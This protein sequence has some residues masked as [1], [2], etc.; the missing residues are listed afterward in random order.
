MAYDQATHETVLFGGFGNPEYYVDTWACRNGWT[1]LAPA[2]SPSARSGP[3]MVWDGA[4]E[5]IVLFGGLSSDGTSLNDTWTWDGSTWTQQFPAASP[6]PRRTTIA[7][8]DPTRTVVLFGGDSTNNAAYNDTWT[9]NGATWTRQSP[10]SAPSARSMASMAYD[11]SVGVVVLF[12][13]SSGPGGRPTIPGHG[14]GPIGPQ[15]TRPMSPLPGGRR[16]WITIRSL[17][18]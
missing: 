3:G 17:R 7:Y 13:G 6:S 9:W 18:A 15:S 12:G 4:A 14:T 8:D 11:A 1:K 16:P 2:S 10:A 5:N